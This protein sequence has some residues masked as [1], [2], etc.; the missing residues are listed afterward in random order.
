VANPRAHQLSDAEIA[1]LARIEAGEHTFR[2]SSAART[3][4]TIDALIDGL[5][6]LRDRGLIRLADSRIMQNQEGRYLGAGPCDLTA[7]GRE[8]LEQDRRL[9]PRA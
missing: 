6:S 8:A 7:T 2:P 1:L 5:R 3:G 9:G 4:E